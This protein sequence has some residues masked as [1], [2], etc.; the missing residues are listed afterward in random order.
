MNTGIKGMKM[1]LQRHSTGDAQVFDPEKV[2]LE[3]SINDNI[4]TNAFTS[5]FLAQLV[6]TSKVVQL[7]QRIEMGNQ[8]I[9]KESVG[10]GEL[11]DAYFVGEA[12]KIGVANIEGAEYTLES[13]KIAV[14]LPVSEEYLKYTWS[15]Y[16]QEV[17]PLIVDKFNKKI[18]GAAFLGLHGNPFGTNVLAAATAASNVIEGDIDTE[19][20]YDLE[21]MTEDSV[22]AFLGHRTINRSLRGLTD[23]VGIN[24]ALIFD[25]PAT[26]T[27]IGQLDGLPYAQLQLVKDETY[28]EGTLFAG[29]WNSLKYGLRAGT[30][31]RLKISD[32]ATLSKIQ[33]TDPDTGDVHLF[34]QDMQ[35][36]RAV[37]EIA[38]AVP[39]GKN[40]AVIKPVGV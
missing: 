16:F 36:L 19:N 6:T 23:G 18:D 8:K 30:S 11:S 37:F 14:I 35:A 40:F 31:L 1:N 7:G 17:L 13:K 21:D 34:E 15:G 5:E 4:A 39:T 25:R 22:N 33:N 38:V 32:M 10:V 24:T 2:M 27:G 3:D 28:P 12:E 26:P 29:N 20:I 9:V